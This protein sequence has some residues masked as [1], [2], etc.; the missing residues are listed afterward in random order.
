MRRSLNIL[1]LYDFLRKAATVPIR[2]AVLVALV[3]LASACSSAGET[4]TDAAAP[5]AVAGQQDVETAASTA[6]PA[7]TATP[8]STAQPAA[9]PAQEDLGEEGPAAVEFDPSLS[10][11]EEA[12]KRMAMTPHR[13]E[14]FFG[15][16]IA[17]E[18]EREVPATAG[19]SDGEWVSTYVG[20]RGG[21]L[22]MDDPAASTISNGIVTYV[23]IT[24]PRRFP[25]V[26]EVI[27]EALSA[28]WILLKVDNLEEQLG[29]EHV[30]DLTPAT[31]TG[32]SDEG[33]LWRGA[34]SIA[35]GP[36]STSRGVA[37]RTIVA[38]I[39][40]LWDSPE[41]SSSA[42]AAKDRA[43]SIVIHIDES[44]YVRGITTDGGGRIEFFDIGTD[45]IVVE[46]PADA[47]DVTSAWIA[48]IET[49]SSESLDDQLTAARAAAERL[50]EKLAEIQEQ[51]RAS[52]EEEAAN[53]EQ[54][55]LEAQEELLAAQ[56]RILAAEEEHQD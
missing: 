24:G 1:F 27:A 47:T 53:R 39:D 45:E 16:G 20:R 33:S 23:S 3:V 48:M 5:A 29:A 50:E 49:R 2:L 54:Q 35:E 11:L 8:G 42:Q 7:P 19:E 30:S 12:S 56:E 9:T 31:F 6:T 14:V 38:E 13:F 28:G 10:F 51:E 44:G 37:T 21:S 26:S 46:L 55:L 22:P 17:R 15:D 43:I 18:A 4:A 25:P 40:P 36:R 32:Q 34:L 41:A 52:Q